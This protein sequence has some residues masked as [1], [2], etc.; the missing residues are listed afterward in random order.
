MSCVLRVD[1]KMRDTAEGSGLLFLELARSKGR[2]GNTLQFAE[3]PLQQQSLHF[4]V[5]W[6]C[7]HHIVLL[8]ESLQSAH[9]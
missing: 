4:P 5:T 2:K 9:E 7:Y 3:N 6:H 8:S 1:A